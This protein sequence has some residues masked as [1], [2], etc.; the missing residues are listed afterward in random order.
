MAQEGPIDDDFWSKKN[1]A[2][3]MGKK[4][5]GVKSDTA[6]VCDAKRL[7]GRFI[8]HH[9]WSPIQVLLLC[10]KLILLSVSSWPILGFRSG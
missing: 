1:R 4:I 6:S 3:W 7:L 10:C 2:I 8:Q 9:C 5:P